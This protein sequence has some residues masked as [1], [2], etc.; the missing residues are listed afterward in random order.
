MAQTERS[1]STIISLLA[2]NASGDISA[3]DIRDMVVS[4]LPSYGSHYIST[5]A[6]TA[7]TLVDTYYE[8]N[9]TTTLGAVARDFDQPASGRLRYTGAPTR[10]VLIT[11]T[12]STTS[13]TN[14]Q[15]LSFKLA[16]NGTVSDETEVQRKVGT[17]SDIEAIAVTGLFSMANNDYISTFVAN[18]TSA[19][20]SITGVN[21]TMAALGIIQ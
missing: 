2:D 13:D 14:N 5:S 15:V 7:V 9:G 17:G 18:S 6:A 21:G 3:Q 12:I 4:V 19:G 8:L 16:K 20:T 11:C 1:L 10:E